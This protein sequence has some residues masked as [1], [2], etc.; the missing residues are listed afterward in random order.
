[1][2][3]AGLK[4]NQSSVNYA[5]FTLFVFLLSIG[6]V[7]VTQDLRRVEMLLR[8]SVYSFTGLVLMTLFLGTDHPEARAALTSVEHWTKSAAAKR[9]TTNSKS[10]VARTVQRPDP[11]L[12]KT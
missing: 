2:L 11:L 1:M 3:V 7:L 12:I 8:R 9:L 4:G 10:D 6:Y 5:A